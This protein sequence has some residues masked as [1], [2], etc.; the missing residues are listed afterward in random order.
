MNKQKTDWETEFDNEFIYQYG[1]AFCCGGD[2]CDGNHTE[3]VSKQ[4]K[5]FISQLL[6]TQREEIIKE[7]EGIV[8]EDENT[9]WEKIGYE[10]A[11]SNESR[12]ELRKEIRERLKQITNSKSK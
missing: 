5:D 12:N 8:G 1:S 4:L 7:I 9:D 3:E 11:C 6:K 10:E 2:Y